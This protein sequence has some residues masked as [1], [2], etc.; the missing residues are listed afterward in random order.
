MSSLGEALG[1]YL[2]Q[3]IHNYRPLTTC[4]PSL[5]QATLRPGDVLL[6]EGNTRVSSAIKYLTQST[7][8]HSAL[9]IGDALAGP[10]AGEDAPRLIEVDMVRGVSAVPLDSYAAFH[11]R[12]CRP[13]A[14]APTDATR[15]VDYAISRLGQTYDL[16]NMIDLAR[17]LLPMPPLPSRWRRRV[18]A[19]GSGDPSKSICS[20]LIAQA[21]MSVGYPI[22]P[23]M[24]RRHS[25]P[26]AE[27][28]N[29]ELL[30]IRHY[31]LYTPRDFDI[32][33]YFEV[34]KPTIEHGFSY[35]PKPVTPAEP[36]RA[37]A[38]LPEPEAEALDLG[39]T[40]DTQAA[41]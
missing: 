37:D 20:T 16:K 4:A 13:I 33:P 19:L 34:V 35:R 28:H 41:T 3:P 9:Y 40:P 24:R 25:D 29:R 10:D 38:L 26:G 2:S 32:S 22:L 1:R 7:W 23:E 12:I 39:H 21:F 15:V 30:Y 6:I 17:Y 8:S 11:T 5:L 27:D 31:S 14:L 36:A 18:L